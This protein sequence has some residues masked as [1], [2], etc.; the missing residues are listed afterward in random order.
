MDFMHTVVRNYWFWGAC[1]GIRQ[2]LAI[3]R[4]FADIE[5]TD[6]LLPEKKGLKK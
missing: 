2:R 4:Y 1:S 6:T 5:N 3:C